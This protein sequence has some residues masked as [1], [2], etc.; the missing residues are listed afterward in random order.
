MIF[1]KTPAVLS[2][3]SLLL[4]G[5]ITAATVPYDYHVPLTP[6][7]VLLGHYRADKKPVLTVKSGATVLIDGGGGAARMEDAASLDQWLKENDIPLTV[8]QSPALQETLKVLKE[9]PRAPGI[10]GGHILVGPIY[11]EGAEPGDSLEVRILDVTPRIPYGT[12]GGAPGRGGLALGMASSATSTASPSASA[13][14][15]FSKVTHLDLARNAGIFNDRIEVPLAPFMGVM[16][17]CPPD[18]EGP[19]RSTSPPGAFGGNLDCKDLI[20]GTTLYLPIFQKGA[21]FYPI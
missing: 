12:T 4:A 18:S 17:T 6:E 10:A 11:V 2:T 20:A 7:N 16:A 21:L 15:P 13:P 3:L 9:T 14:R 8:A 1:I 19:N 5:G